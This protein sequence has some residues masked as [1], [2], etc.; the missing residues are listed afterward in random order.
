[1]ATLHTFA[2]HNRRGVLRLLVEATVRTTLGDR[3]AEQQSHRT[4]VG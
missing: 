1:M 2:V 4:T 3:C